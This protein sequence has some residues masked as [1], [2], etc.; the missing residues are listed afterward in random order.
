MPNHK[1]PVVSERQREIKKL[2]G[3][4]EERPVFRKKFNYE[5]DAEVGKEFKLW[6]IQNDVTAQGKLEEILRD[7]LEK[8]S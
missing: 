6:C 8:Q 2:P 5:I 1:S 7:F 4:S 3:T